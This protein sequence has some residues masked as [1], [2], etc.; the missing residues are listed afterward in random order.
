MHMHQFF[1]I[2]E[3]DGVKTANAS[4]IAEKALLSLN[5]SPTKKASICAI[6]VLAFEEIG[7]LSNEYLNVIDKILRNLRNSEVPFGGVVIMATGDPRQLPPI[8]GK[9]V[10][11]S[12]HIFTT[13]TVYNLKEY[14]RSA[15][16][17]HLM[18]ALRLLQ[19]VHLTDDEMKQYMDIIGTQVPLA[20]Y[21]CS[22]HDAPADAY[23]VVSKN[24]V[25]RAISEEVTAS[26]KAR[27]DAMNVGAAP[28]REKKSKTF[29]ARD[30]VERGQHKTYVELKGEVKAP[31]A[32][33]TLNF[34]REEPEKLYISEGGV[35]KFTVNDTR[36]S[37]TPRFTHGQLCIVKHIVPPGEEWASVEHVSSAFQ[38]IEDVLHMLTLSLVCV[39][40][41]TRRDRAP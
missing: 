27:V 30:F 23:R 10:W 1:G 32:K 37:P 6:D 16:D 2:R 39:C 41:F 15:G 24:V 29:E 40:S 28:G 22:F 8:D 11:I 14:V 5:N 18:D 35:Y 31:W 12:T 9:P 3:V 26:R 33:K 4:R 25:V 13:F 36:T 38:Q 17:Q 19:K 7:L 20:N 21:L 34:L